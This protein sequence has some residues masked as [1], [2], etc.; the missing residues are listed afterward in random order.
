MFN[1]LI[2]T[3]KPVKFEYVRN[4]DGLGYREKCRVVK[5]AYTVYIVKNT[6]TLINTVTSVQ[7]PTH[8]YYNV[9]KTHPVASAMSIDQL[10]NEVS[11]EISCY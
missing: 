5:I 4:E 8:Q 3:K 2:Q 9:V 11:D 1:N 6:L 10:L 7:D